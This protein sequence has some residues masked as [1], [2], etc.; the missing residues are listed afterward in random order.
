MKGLDVLINE[1]VN[2]YIHNIINESSYT[3]QLNSMEELLAAMN[4]KRDDVIDDI[5]TKM[6]IINGIVNDVNA[7]ITR[8]HEAII[9]KFGIQENQITYADEYNAE[10]AIYYH[11]DGFDDSI[12]YY[13]EL[14]DIKRSFLP[15]NDMY[16]DYPLDDIITVYDDESTN[17]I[18]LK[19]DL[20]YVL[21]CE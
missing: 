12:D 9:S 20:Y 19:W 13:S 17:C 11:V 14:L 1:S 5:Q 4:D 21:K 18:E 6:S 10:Y 7:A 16:S 3:T 15:K 8:I 2:K